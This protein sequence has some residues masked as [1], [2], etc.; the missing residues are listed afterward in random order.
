[1]LGGYFEAEFCKKMVH[2]QKCRTVVLQM[3]EKTAKMQNF[4]LTFI[5]KFCK[6]KKI[7]LKC[8]TFFAF[9]GRNTGQMT[10]KFCKKVNFIVKCRTAVLHFR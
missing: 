8:R 10:R 3:I 9:A 4:F 7:G 6:L 1:M 2:V 5:K